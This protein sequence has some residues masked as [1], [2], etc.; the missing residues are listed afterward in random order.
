[1]VTIGDFAKFPTYE[2]LIYLYFLVVIRCFHTI[3]RCGVKREVIRD[4]ELMKQQQH[5]LRKSMKLGRMSRLCKPHSPCVTICSLVVRTL[6][7]Y[8]YGDYSNRIIW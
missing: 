2:I 7:D 1:M 8:F 6:F 3:A 5:G 4:N